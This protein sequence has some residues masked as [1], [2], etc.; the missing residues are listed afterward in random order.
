M[1]INKVEL[2]EKILKGSIEYEFIEN[3]NG[4]SVLKIKSYYGNDKIYIN[5]YEIIHLLKH[6]TAVDRVLLTEKEYEEYEEN[7]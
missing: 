6:Y 5:F 2:L 7:M 1:E 4:D 3:C